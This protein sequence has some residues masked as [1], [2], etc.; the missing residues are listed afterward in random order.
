MTTTASHTGQLAQQAF[1]A[2]KLHASPG[3]ALSAKFMGGD[4]VELT[5]TGTL[6]EL[7][8][9]RQLIDFGSYAVTLLGHRHPNVLAAL[10]A[11]LELMP[12]STRVLANPTVTVLLETLAERT[13]QRLPRVWLGSDGADA[14]EVA[15]KLARRVSG[16][17]RI[18]AVDGAFHGKTLGALALT[19]NPAFRI[20]LEQHLNYVTHLSLD[21]P[22]AVAREVKR[23]DV[24][25]LIIEP[26]QGESGVRVLDHSLLRQW[27]SDAHAAG[28]FVISD[29]IQVGLG[30][31]GP[32]SLALD[33]GVEPDA[34]LLGKA[35]GGGVLPLSALLATAR[36]YE[37]I[38]R[39][40]TWHSATFA[41]HPLSAAAACA[42][43]GVLG[44][45][46]GDVDRLASR[47]G[48]RLRR[49]AEVHGD[50]ISDVRGRGLLWGIQLANVGHAGALL[51]ELA[52]GGLLTSPCLS[53]PDTIR[54]APPIT[55]SD[56]QLE[57]ALGILDGGLEAVG[58]TA[59]NAS[60]A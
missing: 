8:D 55:T 17:P 54:L 14:V 37:P 33:A 24:A 38:A 30:R 43:L 58:R 3:A 41:G 1:A 44:E 60:V 26:I 7:S 50:V 11:Q 40:P 10:F 28:A 9:G 51:L 21:D 42:T 2:L 16:R 48:E 31:C 56:E 13:D 4:A 25:A 52:A 15:V 47:L 45:R 35:L 19:W 32:F 22:A 23:G 5:A 12:T 18:L 59:A 46:R 53:A 57:Q 29:E 20:G 39:D 6:V 34:V 27:A 36:L 49:L